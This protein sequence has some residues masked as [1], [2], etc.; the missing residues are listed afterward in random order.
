MS[1][2]FVAM[3][4]AMKANR[5]FSAVV[6]IQKDRGHRV[7]DQGPYAIV[8]HP[9]YA[10]MMPLMVFSGF[11]FGSWLAVAAGVVY[12]TLIAR[13][14]VFEDAYLRANLPGYQDYTGRVRYRLLKGVW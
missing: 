1:L 8:R 2:C 12:A 14:I 13:R 5:F 9:G 11:A 3:V 10:A 7:V 6:R 4:H